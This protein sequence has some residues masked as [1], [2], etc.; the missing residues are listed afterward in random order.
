MGLY[1]N[2]KTL[3]IGLIGVIIAAAICFDVIAFTDTKV[4]VSSL[5][6]QN[7]LLDLADWEPGRDGIISL[8]GGWDFYWNRFLS[9]DELKETGV[10]ADI[11][12]KVPA[13]WNNYKINGSSLPG[14]GYATYRLKVINANEDELIA[15]HIP[16]MSTSYRMYINEKLVAS[17]GT[18]AAEKE[19][20]SP[21]YRPKTVRIAA[22]GA[23]FDIV[24][25]ISNF[26]YS[27]GG[28]WY[29]IDMGTPEQV[30]NLNKRIIYRDIFLFSIFFIMGLYYLSIFMMRREDKSSLYFVL[31]CVVVIGRTIIH[32]DYAVYRLLPFISFSAIVFINYATLYWFPTAFLLL[33]KELFPEEVSG[34]A[35]RATVIYAAVITLITL[36]LPLHIYTRYTCFV[37]AMLILT[38]LYTIVCSCIAFLKGKQDSLIVLSGA[39]AMVGGAAY[40]ILVYLKLI[41]QYVG[42]VSSFGFFV[43]LFLES[44]VLARRFSQ[45][46]KNVNEMSGKLMKIDKLK[47]EFLANTSHELRTPLNGILGITEGMLRGS[48]GELNDGQRQSLSI[49]ALSCRRL[50]YLVNDILDYSRLKYSDIKLNLSPL[51]V[52][53]VIETTLNEFRQLTNPQRVEISSTIPNGLPPVMADENRLAQIMYNL[54]GNAVKCTNQGYIRVMA[55][56]TGEMLEICIEDTGEG[57][58]EEKFSDI[59]KSFEQVDTS[60]ARKYGGTGLGLPITKFLI[61]SH[62]GSIWVAS[63]VGKGA[64][65]TFTLPITREQFAKN[66]AQIPFYGIAAAAG[67]PRVIRIPGEGANILVADD[68][69]VNLQSAAAILKTEGYSITAV[70]SGKAALEEVRKQSDI[71]L[72]I[73]DVMMPEMSGYEVC[74]II[75]DNRSHYELPVLMLTAKTTTEDIV[76]GFKAGANDYLPKPVEAEELL[77]RVKTLVNLKDSVDKAKAAE[78]AFLQAQIKPHFLFNVLNTISSFCDSDPE[79]AGKLIND[80]A[81]YLR[82]SFDFKNLD[83]F[84]PLDTEI[85]LIKS[86]LE[87]EKARFGDEMSVE[88]VLD[89]SI[90]IDIPPLS[91]QPLIENAIRHGLRKR[92][93][94]GIVTV[95]VG[96]VADG[97]RV[98]VSDNGPGIPADKLDRLF[99]AENI[100][101]IGLK[102]IHF[103]LKK[104]YGIGLFIESEPGK[105]TK[106]SFIVPVGGDSI[107]SGNNS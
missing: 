91:I 1:K 54:V 42:E 16:T 10:E 73:L 8:S 41:P 30:E 46:F 29:S 21:E 72:L 33:L 32:G 22:P 25:H 18:T 43:L 64:K 9:S 2:G 71:S 63:E 44:F 52:E 106:V 19:N 99:T 102:N 107:D 103:R 97:V 4:R 6:P 38:S 67:E 81:N 7:G 12:A 37:L 39:L 59:F 5:S 58:P 20:F 76:R 74:R 51:R 69:R 62:G 15:F 93:G 85:S 101:G 11:K 53:A 61:E 60:L 56:E 50:S 90:Q 68:E 3:I 34:K 84:V 48:E 83:L 57:I 79:R 89:D 66:E 28:M 17:N 26:I 96:K 24:V 45:A 55:K 75:R 82:H 98:A 77:A 27:R 78:V 104:I 86:Y 47:D 31:M 23:Q 88:F 70:N 80:L 95:S 100:S 92:A 36:L 35:V 40:D 87:I 49:V 14:F 65:F 94:G 13:V 105:G